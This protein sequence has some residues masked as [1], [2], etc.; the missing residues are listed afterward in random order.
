MVRGLVTYPR[1]RAERIP[2]AAT[3]TSFGRAINAYLLDLNQSLLASVR[4]QTR[5]TW[6][7]PD[8][9][10]F[11]AIR[12]LVE[13]RMRR[14]RS[15]AHRVCRLLPC[16]HYPN[17]LRCSAEPAEGDIVHYTVCRC[18]V[19]EIETLIVSVVPIPQ[20]NRSARVL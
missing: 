2:F 7:P 14:Y 8:I 19:F 20:S 5:N 6:A 10:R 16:F 9:G 4:L 1:S 11:L 3:T 17:P 15:R 13:T 12:A 18:A